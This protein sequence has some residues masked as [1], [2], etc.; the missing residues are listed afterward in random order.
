MYIC[1]NSAEKVSAI[2]SGLGVGMVGV[3]VGAVGVKRCVW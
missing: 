3:G 1:R 2:Y